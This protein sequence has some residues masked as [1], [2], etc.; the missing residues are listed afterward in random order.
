MP[1]VQD[2]KNAK[3]IEEHISE[4]EYEEEV[5]VEDEEVEE[6]EVEEADATEDSKRKR[7]T[8]LEL[9]DELIQ[10]FNNIEK[11]EAK[12]NEKQKEFDQVQKE[13]NTD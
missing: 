6:E 11:A 9:F 13:F 5:D 3:P 4:E 1:K 12:F 10:R 7:L 2:K 8:P